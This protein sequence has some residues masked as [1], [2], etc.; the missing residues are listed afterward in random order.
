MGMFGTGFAQFRFDEKAAFCYVVAAGWQSSKDLGHLS[1]IFSKHDV[2][3]FKSVLRPDKDRRLPFDRLDGVGP[4][5]RTS[6]GS[7]ERPSLVPSAIAHP[8]GRS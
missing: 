6:S 3:A 8:G 1:I 2:V 5:A 7:Q 4:D